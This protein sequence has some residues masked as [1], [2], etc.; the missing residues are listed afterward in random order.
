[1]SNLPVSLT[2][3]GSEVAWRERH[4][5][6]LNESGS[7]PSIGFWESALFGWVKSTGAKLH[8]FKLDESFIN[9]TT[10]WMRMRPVLKILSTNLGAAIIG[11]IL[12]TL[13]ALWIL[14]PK[15]HG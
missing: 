2:R 3:L 4:R 11:A 10:V 6:G 5:G 13:L 8:R 7:R 15:S 12:C 14:V 1:M 9:P